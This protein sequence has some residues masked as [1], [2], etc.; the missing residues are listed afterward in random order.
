MRVLIAAYAE[1][2][3]FF[4]MVPIAWAL[5]TAGH[6]VR[7]ASQPALMDTIAA[8]GLTA[9]SV[10]ADHSW[11][12]LMDEMAD[13]EEWAERV[14]EVLGNADSAD[15]ETLVRFFA[16]ETKSFR[17]FNDSMVDD[18]VTFARQWQ[19]DLVLWEHFTFAA[20]I[21]ARVV[22]AAHV[23]V[24]WG[25]DVLIQLRQ[26]FLAL[27]EKEPPEQR[28]DVL[29]DWLD[30]TLARFG[31][32][33]DEEILTGQRTLEQSPSSM[34]LPVEVRTVTMR[35]VPY[36]GPSVVPD[37]LREPP[38]RPR[39]CITAGVS[40]RAFFGFDPIPLSSLRSFAGLDVEVVATL[41][42]QEGDDTEI[43]DN[44]RLVDFVPMH[45][46]LPTCAAVVHIG[47]AGI[48]STALTYGVPQLVLVPDL[49]DAP[50]RARMLAEQGAG[51]ELTPDAV[52]P[53]SIRDAVMRLV[54]EPAFREAA[55]R[56]RDEADAEPAPNEVVPVLERLAAEP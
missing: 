33:F 46:I 2:T 29:G 52:T 51:L 18:L 20:P 11:Q 35:Y 42:R 44:V 40:M 22:G 27:R 32:R 34:R 54:T 50:V 47:S 43:P 26:R 37:W 31:H 48:V 41:V 21:A 13:D 10:G 16:E 6:E 8:S 55:I 53:E 7:V 38:G 19:P 25:A 14:T 15:H 9:V 5:R 36:N 17:S 28:S 30:D 23:R 56:L 1:R 4:H 12:D 3:H 39:V 49:W 45:A 24:L